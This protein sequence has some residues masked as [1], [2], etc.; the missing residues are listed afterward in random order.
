M[1]FQTETPNP[2]NLGGVNELDPR[3]Q[4]DFMLRI[5][6]Q[7]EQQVRAS[8]AAFM[9][10][11]LQPPGA[12]PNGPPTA[13]HAAAS[14]TD[15]CVDGKPL[16][17]TLT[18][19]VNYNWGNVVLPQDGNTFDVSTLDVSR[20]PTLLQ[21]T[22]DISSGTSNNQKRKR[23]I[24]G[25][26]SE[27][28][29]ITQALSG[30]VS[31]KRKITSDINSHRKLKQT[32]L[33]SFFNVCEKS[34]SVDLDRENINNLLALDT[35]TPEEV[36]VPPD[37]EMTRTHY[38]DARIAE[39][40]ERERLIFSEPNP[41]EN[42]SILGQNGTVDQEKLSRLQ[43][44]ISRHNIKLFELGLIRA[45]EYSKKKN[46]M[47]DSVLTGINY[48]SCSNTSNGIKKKNQNDTKINT[49]SLT[50]QEDDGPMTGGTKSTWNRSRTAAVE[51]IK[52]RTR[53]TFYREAPRQEMAEY[54]CFGLEKTPGYLMKIGP[55]RTSLQ[56]MRK[57]HAKEIMLLAADFLDKEMIRNNE[58]ASMMKAAALKQIYEA[59]PRDAAD[60]IVKEASTS[61]DVTI[62]NMGS[63][64]FR[65]FEKRRQLLE[66]SPPT[67]GDILDPAG[68]V[69][70]NALKITSANTGGRGGN[71]Q[72]FQPRG[73]GNRGGPRSWRGKNARKPYSR[74]DRN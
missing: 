3:I 26:A 32:N 70:R 63:N 23:E 15:K 52:A 9:P 1:E 42:M 11:G 66:S 31:K 20:E 60:K 14:D 18:N 62:S 17:H 71:N 68:N 22:Y 30:T 7:I 64:E 59:N 67:A 47:K 53:A 74:S 50:I 4:A 2:A 48:M 57:R 46:T 58:S 38:I 44:E 25:D 65:E 51:A 73:R 34:N 24:S 28:T 54:W 16:S 10:A 36:V 8:L 41:V 35:T 27:C 56:A 49:S 5:G 61:Y 21:S 13:G 69:A 12:N 39:T 29:L 72:G 43:E 45:K 6:Q 37:I 33:N 40:K 55:F 19:D